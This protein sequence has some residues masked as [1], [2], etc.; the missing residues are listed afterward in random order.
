MFARLSLFALVA[1]LSALG[2]NAQTCN[3]QAY[4]VIQGDTCIAIADKLGITL[5]QL[6]G[7]NPQ[8]NAACS[9]LIPDEQLATPST[10]CGPCITSYTVQPG[11]ICVNIASEF[12]ITLEELLCANP[13]INPGCTNLQINQVLC[14]V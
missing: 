8:I 6:L 12:G 11:D 14:I 3:G 2:T 9:N 7:C 13:A 1:S 10:T 4:T 5:A